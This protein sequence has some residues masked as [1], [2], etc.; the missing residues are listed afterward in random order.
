MSDLYIRTDYK[1]SVEDFEE[2]TDYEIKYISKQIDFIGV[3]ITLNASGSTEDIN[4]E[5]SKQDLKDLH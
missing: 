5:I 2:V 4:I 1:N 3:T